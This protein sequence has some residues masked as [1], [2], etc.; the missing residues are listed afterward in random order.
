MSDIFYPIVADNLGRV[1]LA[2]D[3]D[4]DPKEHRVV[5]A[6]IAALFWREMLVNILPEDSKGI[7]I[8]IDNECT[9][10]FTYRV[11]GHRA[12]YRG[13]GDLHE[14]TYDDLVIEKT[15]AGL[16]SFAKGVSEYSGAELDPD[17]CPFSFRVYPSDQLKSL[18][19]TINRIVFTMAAVLI[20]AFTSLVFWLYDR[21]VEKRQRAVLRTAVDS[22]AIVSSLF[23]S[24][25]RHRLMPSQQQSEQERLLSTGS[26]NTDLLPT[27]GISSFS[28]API[29]E[30]YPNTT[31]LFADIAGFTV[32]EL[33]SVPYWLSSK[34]H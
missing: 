26:E 17:F 32:R 1:E 2:D 16:D 15:L 23:P 10:S 9:Q 11:D 4:Y 30:L 14:D 31:V 12:T 8:V 20:F 27:K 3:P 18:H 6:V 28:S 22:T 19:T 34:Y 5:G 24:T 21:L 7:D 13:V 33:A 25:V 29:A